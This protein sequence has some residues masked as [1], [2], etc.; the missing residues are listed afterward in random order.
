MYISSRHRPQTQMYNLTHVR[1]APRPE[2]PTLVVTCPKC[3]RG[4][5][6]VLSKVKHTRQKTHKYLGRTKYICSRSGS[7]AQ[8]LLPGALIK[9]PEVQRPAILAVCSYGCHHDPYPQARYIS[10]PENPSPRPLPHLSAIK[11]RPARRLGLC[12]PPT[13]T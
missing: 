5:L 4:H 1:A 11:V 13:I 6:I 9:V 7:V 12:S 3:Q 2:S 10:H 8:G